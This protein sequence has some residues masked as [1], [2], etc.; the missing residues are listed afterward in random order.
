MKH[1]Q[2]EKAH[3]DPVCGMLVSRL[4]AAADAGHEGK[5]YYFCAPECRDAFVAEPGKFLL[6]HR[7]HGLRP[8]N[9]DGINLAPDLGKR[10]DVST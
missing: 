2:D 4:T 6:P 7:Q 3:K 5:T 10:K 1:R 9:S 8:N